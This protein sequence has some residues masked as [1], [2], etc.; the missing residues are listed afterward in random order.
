MAAKGDG[1]AMSDDQWLPAKTILID[2]SP[3]LAE[4]WRRA[5][6]VFAEVE[7]L[8]G[9]YFQRPADA[10]VSPA[11]SFGF[12]DGGLDLA[13]RNTLG[14]QVQ[15]RVQRAILDNH[16]GELP[17]GSAEIVATDHPR[18]PY[19]ISAPTMRVPESVAFSIN[20]Y[21]A[22]RAVLVAVQRFNR[23]EGPRKITSLVCSGL[24]TGIGG[25][26]PGKCATQMLLAYNDML[27]P[28]RIRRFESIHEQQAA[29]RMS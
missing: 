22:F 6:G 13:I 24:G 19:L 12:M 16:H 28:P 27:M 2:S 9:D 20:A 7:V 26:S 18:W 17:V 14:D 11:N 8:S 29:L 3:Q 10:I 23:R 15:H 5:F 25:I 4:E 21:L 1:H